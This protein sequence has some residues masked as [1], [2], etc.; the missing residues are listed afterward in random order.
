M[1]NILPKPQ[2]P[3]TYLEGHG[4][5]VYKQVMMGVTGVTIRVIG[6][7]SILTT[8]TLTWRDIYKQVMMGVTGVTIWDIGVIS[9]LT[10]Y[11]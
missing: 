1:K 5:L 11:H 4:D 10:K 7:I 9:I 2:T 3:N 6:V 8:R